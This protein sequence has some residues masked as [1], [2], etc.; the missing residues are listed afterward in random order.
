MEN[1]VSM[2]TKTDTGGIIA[3]LAQMAPETLIDETALSGIFNRCPTSIKRAVRR[4]ELP[5]PVKLFGKPTWTARAVLD[6]LNRRLEAAK[7]DAD[8]LE[9]RISQL[10][11]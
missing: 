11:A 2:Q 8:R 9:K 7:R 3:A 4:Q 1:E 5:R 10:S 6:H